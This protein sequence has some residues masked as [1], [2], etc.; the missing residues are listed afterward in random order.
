TMLE[1]SAAYLT[2]PGYRDDG[3]KHYFDF[4]DALYPQIEHTLEGALGSDGF[5][6]LHGGDSRFVLPSLEQMKRLTMSDLKAWMA[7]PLAKGYLEVSIVGDVD[8]EVALKLVAKT[9]GALP[10]RDADKP[11]FASERQTKFPTDSKLKEISIVSQTPCGMV[12]VYWP[13]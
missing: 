2:A 12:S 11:D 6:F 9:L 8:P 10:E 13:T 3:H 7:R 4:L 1:M 5:A